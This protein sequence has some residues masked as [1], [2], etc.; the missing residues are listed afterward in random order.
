MSLGRRLYNIARAELRHAFRFS[1]R[2]D[3]AAENLMEE[4][5]ARA[6]VSSAHEPAPRVSLEDEKIRRY[7]ANLEL[8]YGATAA[9]VRAAYRRLVRR[10]H[11]D[12]HQADT[13]AAK[14][15]TEITQKL[16]VAHDGLLA[17]LEAAV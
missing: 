17:H 10:Y 3:R 13:E 8:P 7:Y 12:K 6:R 16:R 2:S 5:L 9:E 11:P 15:A 1:R 4:E 14:V